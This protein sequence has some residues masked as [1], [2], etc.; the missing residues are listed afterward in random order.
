M[1]FFV[2]V[3]IG[4]TPEIFAKHWD[5]VGVNCAHCLNRVKREGLM[6]LAKFTNI[7]W[8]ITKCP[9]QLSSFI[10]CTVVHYQNLDFVAYP[11]QRILEASVYRPLYFLTFI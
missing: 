11:V 2:L 1:P 8:L 5:W 4:R 6:L 7:A 9:C 3:G 10:M